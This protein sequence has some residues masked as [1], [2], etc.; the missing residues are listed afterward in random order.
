MRRE[1]KIGI[2]AV[3][4]LG[5]MWAGIR[6][7]SGIDIFSRNIPYYVT[8]PE[9]TGIQTAT[10]VTIQGV[11]VGTVTDIC[12]NPAVSR[13]VVLRLTV[14]KNYRLPDNSVVRIYSDGIMGGKAIA[15]DLGD[16]P[17]TFVKGDT[18]PTIASSDLL[19]TAGTELSDVKQRLTRVMDNLSTTLESVNAIL[20][21][22]KTNID[23]TL[24]H[25][26]SISGTMDGVLTK[27]QGNLQRAIDNITRFSTVLGDN[28]ERLS[29][30]V[31]NLDNFSQQ[32]SRSEVDSLI[33]G[34]RTTVDGLNTTLVALNEGEGSAGRLLNDPSLYA[35]L[36][37]AASNLAALLGDLKEHPKRYVHFSLF[38]RKD[39][40]T[41]HTVSSNDST[42]TTEQIA[43]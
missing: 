23:G 33:R 34:L 38:G 11:K 27:E 17:R 14:R 12:F 19:A 13:N 42:T 2:F 25:M 31:E 8:Y 41:K 29:S 20:Q 22:N 32:L 15:I 43:E 6:F 24:A 26:N 37:E 39:K 18:L 1:V 28:S 30:M 10:P 21:D 16:S 9:V 3:V 35:S 7:L 4:M 40:E 36:N 5:C